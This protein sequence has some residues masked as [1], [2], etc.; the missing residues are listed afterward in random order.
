[1]EISSVDPQKAL[2]EKLT[3]IQPYQSECDNNFFF[4]PDGAGTKVTWTMDGVNETTAQ[5]WMILVFKGSITDDF[6]HGLAKLKQ[7]CESM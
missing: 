4:A 5:R 3:F 1:M 6:T 2:L 7:H